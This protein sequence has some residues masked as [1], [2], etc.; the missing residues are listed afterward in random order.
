MANF[1]YH[2]IWT[3]QFHTGLTNG[4]MNMKLC[5][6]K[7][8]SVTITRADRQNASIVRTL[9]DLFIQ[10]WFLDPISIPWINIDPKQAHRA[11]FCSWTNCW[12]TRRETLRNS[13]AWITA[14]VDNDQPLFQ[15]QVRNNIC[16]FLYLVV[17]PSVYLYVSGLS[18]C[19]IYCQWPAPFPEAGEEWRVCVPVRVYLSVCLSICLSYFLLFQT[20]TISSFHH[21]HHPL[22]L[23]L[24]PLS[25]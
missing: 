17:R 5:H 8:I 4:T 16:L 13:L 25:T 12:P 19:F 14:S 20:P 18:V 22:H 10:V 11:I 21:H 23:Y 2:P 1:F 15:I 7:D 6:L 9:F 24:F 3:R